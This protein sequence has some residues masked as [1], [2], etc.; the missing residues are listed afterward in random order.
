MKDC[1]DCRWYLGAGQCRLNVES[2]CAEGGGYELWDDKKS[3]IL[4]ETTSTSYDINDE[5]KNFK[6]AL[7]KMWFAYVNK[8][9]DCPADYEMDAIFTARKLLGDWTN[10]MKLLNY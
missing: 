5:L 2:E 8:D 4:D 3:N 10:A 1:S 7:A 6:I 9:E